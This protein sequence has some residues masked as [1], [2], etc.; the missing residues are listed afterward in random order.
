M[1]SEFSIKQFLETGKTKP[2]YKKYLLE[3]INY[4]GDILSLWFWEYQGSWDVNQKYHPLEKPRPIEITQ[5]HMKDNETPLFMSVTKFGISI[6]TF[7][8]VLVG[9]QSLCLLNI[10]LMN[11]QGKTTYILRQIHKINY[12]SFGDIVSS[13]DWTFFVWKK[14]GFFIIEESL[15]FRERQKKYSFT[16]DEKTFYYF[17]LAYQI[18]AK[19]LINNEKL[20]QLQKNKEKK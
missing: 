13:A 1:K 2:K 12:N 11:G 7:E 6:P 18:V 9:L 10:G 4:Q 14:M 3:I 16:I 8:T 19:D 17:T 20:Y 5:K 15:L